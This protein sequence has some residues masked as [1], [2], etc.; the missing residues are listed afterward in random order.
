MEDTLARDICKKDVERF[1][2]DKH[3]ATCP[4]CGR[5]R[6]DC[7][8]DVKTLSGQRVCAA[9]TSPNAEINILMIV[10]QNCGA[11]QFHDRA[12]VCRWLERQR[13]VR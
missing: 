9:D 8:V 10:C 1:L 11:I 12:I 13:P 3:L 5:F 2:L 6:S 4:V 7:D